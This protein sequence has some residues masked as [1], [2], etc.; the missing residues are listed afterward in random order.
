[1]KHLLLVFN[2]VAG[3]KKASKRLPEII[4]VSNR[5]GYDVNVYVTDGQR[6][7]SKAVIEM[8]R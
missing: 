5:A 6:D 3:M 7:A 4:S 1:M 8:G 2:P